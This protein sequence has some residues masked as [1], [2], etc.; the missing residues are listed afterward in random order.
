M[1]KSVLSFLLGSTLV[2]GGLLGTNNVSNNVSC[3][4]ASGYTETIYW[5][6]DS[7]GCLNIGTSEYA[8]P[9]IEKSGNF[10]G[11]SVLKPGWGASASTRDL[12][13]KIRFDNK[14]VPATCAKW[15]SFLDNLTEIEN[16]EYLDVSHAS[17][18]K[19]MFYSDKK[20]KSLDLSSFNTSNVTDLSNMFEDDLALTSVNFE[21]WNVESVTDFH[22]M[23]KH[24]DKISTLDLSSFKTTSGKSFTDMFATMSE[25][26]SID[27]SN[28]KLSNV[29]DMSGMFSGCGKL[30][31]LDT[32]NWFLFVQKI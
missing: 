19:E 27:V 17:S 28:F 8:A 13:K 2:M 5:G 7:D 12:I 18:F 1:K 31:T 21:G 4:E 23:F 24:C 20:L 14:I 30:E 22:N 25:V 9:N 16:L 29:T 3:V 32:S 11:N 10:A 15:F 6:I 26:T